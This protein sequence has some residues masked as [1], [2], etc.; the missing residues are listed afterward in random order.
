MATIKSVNSKASVQEK[1]RILLE[2]AFK[3]YDQVAEEQYLPE[4]TLDEVLNHECN[5]DDK[6]FLETMRSVFFQ[7]DELKT[8]LNV[9][10]NKIFAEMLEGLLCYLVKKA[11]QSRR[12]GAVK[13]AIIYAYYIKPWNNGVTYEKATLWVNQEY[14]KTMNKDRKERYCSIEPNEEPNDICRKKCKL[15]V[16]DIELDKFISVETFGDYKREAFEY[17][18]PIFAD[19]LDKLSNCTK[20]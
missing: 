16:R 15:C 8:E 1:S 4:K 9:Q 3:I 13:G 11:S 14:I 2:N 5:P 17:L 20:L 6:T 19:L 10:N 7:D 18:E 12:H